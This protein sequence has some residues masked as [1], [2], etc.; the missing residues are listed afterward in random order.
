MKKRSRYEDIKFQ[1]TK[2][3][4]NAYIIVNMLCS[5]CGMKFANETRLKI[6]C[7]T[8]KKRESKGKKQ[9][10]SKVLPDFDKPDFS[11]VM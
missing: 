8:H 1:Q 4:K 11:Q 9:K 6:H 2:F 10:Q 5:E 3:K 7:N